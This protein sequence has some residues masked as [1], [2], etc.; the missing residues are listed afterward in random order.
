MTG[1]MGHCAGCAQSKEIRHAVPRTMSYKA[2]RALELSVADLA[3]PTPTS[4]GVS[5]FCLIVVDGLSGYG[6]AL[7]M[8]D[9]VG[10]TVAH[11]S[12]R[13]FLVSLKP[14]VHI[15]GPPGFLRT[16]DGTESTNEGLQAL[17]L[18]FRIAR[19]LTPVGGHKIQGRAERKLALVA[20]ADGA[21]HLKFH[22]TSPT[23]FSKC[24]R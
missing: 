17:L 21:A 18:E 13:M 6:W 14:L 16:D 20:E 7:F 4:G 10:A 2:S 19:Q 23:Q 1:R 22:A 8:P 9:K 3:A 12:F 24:L 11:T 15:H 5:R